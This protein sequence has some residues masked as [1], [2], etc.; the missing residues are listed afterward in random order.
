MFQM[1]LDG[2]VTLLSRVNFTRARSQRFLKRN[3][4]A[5][6]REDPFDALALQPIGNEQ[7]TG[8]DTWVTI[9][10]LSSAAFDDRI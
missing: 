1:I 5:H 10:G 7:P 4:Q 2:K 9:L 3:S 8:G 6:T